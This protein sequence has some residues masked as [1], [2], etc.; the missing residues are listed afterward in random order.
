M[1]CWPRLL[2]RALCPFVREAIMAASFGY[3][4]FVLAVLIGL[5]ILI[6]W[7]APKVAFELELVFALAAVLAP[8]VEWLGK[9]LGGHRG[10]AVAVVSLAVL[11]GALL[12]VVFVVPA[13]VHSV[14]DIIASIKTQ[15]PALRQVLEELM[16]KLTPYTGEMDLDEGLTK[17]IE[18][19][20]KQ[21][22]SGAALGMLASVSVNVILGIGQVIVGCVIL[23]ILCSGWDYFVDWAKTLTARLAPQNAPRVI[24]IAQS[25]A[26]HGIA[27]F[28]GMGIMAIIF[29]VSYAVILAVVGL[30]PGRILLY[31][32]VLGLFSALPGVGGFVSATLSM[33]IALSH[34]SIWDWQGWVLV[35]SGILAHFVEAKFLT[36]R[37]VGHAIDVPGF[38]MIGA[39]LSGITVNGVPGVFQALMLLPVLRALVDEIGCEEGE[40]IAGKLEPLPASVTALAPEPPKPSVTQSRHKAKRR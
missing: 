5:L 16:L 33:L 10:V 25:A 4:Q 39:I 3:R 20:Q 8:S 14:R 22:A 34:F 31:A 36:P 19:L 26:R 6:H 2:A 32:I 28:R 24:R 18:I 12:L 7:S 17:L 15:I 9:R 30:P 13:L 40:P 23:A 1:L 21:G 11:V 38:V 29:V 27:M 37:I 35:G